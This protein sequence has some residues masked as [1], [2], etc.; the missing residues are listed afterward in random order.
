[1]SVYTGIQKKFSL[2]LLLFLLMFSFNKSSYWTKNEQ[3]NKKENIATTFSSSLKP[4]PSF[5]CFLVQNSTAASSLVPFRFTWL[6]SGSEC[7]WLVLPV[8]DII[9]IH[10]LPRPALSPYN[11]RYTGLSG[12]QRQHGIVAVGL[13]QTLLPGWLGLRPL[14]VD[15]RHG[16]VAVGVLVA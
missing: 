4:L 13:L 5:G 9:K 15:E 12:K 6:L 10:S 11:A 2:L 7:Q 14:S 8:T 1:M 16:D 3:T